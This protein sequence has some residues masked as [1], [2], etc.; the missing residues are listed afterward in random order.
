MSNPRHPLRSLIST[1]AFLLVVA[2]ETAAE[3][4]PGFKLEGTK[5]TYNDGQLSMEGILIKPDGDG[6]FPAILVS[7]GRGGNAAGFGAMKAS[8]FVKWG[9]VCIAPNYTHA[10][11]IGGANAKEAGGRG[12][13]GPGAGQGQ[14]KGGDGQ[15]AAAASG[16]APGGTESNPTGP[17]ASDE[18]L[19]RA[20]KCL[21]I[22]ERFPYVDAKRL[23]AYG[24]SMGAFVT[25]GLSAREANRLKAAA[26]TAGGISSR[27]GAPAESAGSAARVPLCIL[28]GGSDTTVPPESSV[29]LKEML[30]RNNVPNER[31]IFEGVGHNLHQEKADEVFRLIKAWFIKHEV[32]SNK[33]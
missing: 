29:R 23:A 26:I 27:G 9:F 30:D 20:S 1:F 24:N 7:H 6:P 2:V 25:V 15:N 3:P 14:K 5:W 16:K 8:E 22:L 13:R 17:G 31:H 21:D 10:G 18:N 32:L 12:P 19:R 11:P 28:H 4:L 33:T